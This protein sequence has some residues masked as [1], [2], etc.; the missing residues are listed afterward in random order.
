MTVTVITAAAAPAP[1]ATERP[2]VQLFPHQ[3]DAVQ[4]MQ[5]VEQRPRIVPEQPHGGI[6]AH[7]MGLG[8][9]ITMLSLVQAQGIG[10]T[11]V[12][13]PKSVLGQWREEA[14]R[15][16]DIP[17][18]SIVMYHGT[19]RQ[20]LMDASAPARRLILT[21]FDIVRLNGKQETDSE[22]ASNETQPSLLHQLHWDRVIL[23]EAHRICEQGSKTARAIRALKARNRWCVTG[24]PFKN[25]VT[26]LVALSKFLLVP[27]Y[28]N[29]TWWRCHSQNK[30]KLREW[31]NTF[32][33]MQDKS[34]LKLPCIDEVLLSTPRTTC[35][36]EFM[37]VIKEASILTPLSSV[38]TAQA[39]AAGTSLT[40][41][42]VTDMRA[43][44]FQDTAPQQEHEL[45]KIMRL[46][47]AANHP[48]MLSNSTAT[49][50]RLLSLDDDQEES[51]RSECSSCGNAVNPK[52]RRLDAAPGCTTK[53]SHVMCTTCASDMIA[54]MRCLAASLPVQRGSGKVFRHSGKTKALWDYLDV[55]LHRDESAKAVLFSQWT[56]CLDLL[57]LM[58]DVMGIK[59][60]RFDGRVN[61]IDERGDII[62][63]F[64][65]DPT[66]RVLLTSLGAG[67]EGLN[68]TFANHVILMEPYWNCAAEQQ[69]IDRLHRMGQS[70]VTNVLR[71]IAKDSIEDWV[72][73]IQVKKT[74]ELE[75]LLRGKDDPA[76]IAGMKPRPIFRCVD[77]INSTS[78]NSAGHVVFGAR[79]ATASA[80]SSISSLAQYL[81]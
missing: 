26:D 67:G 18:E 24:T 13:C 39:A 58:L 36:N 79:C 20:Q 62:A 28:C 56:T 27:P 34:V 80:M 45:L 25:G 8:K 47:Q 50:M 43:L 41:D 7:A 9:T 71:L 66:C 74:R 32:L 44:L 19:N 72:Q 38:P 75:R 17:S 51:D 22:Q 29:A 63:Q 65:E 77:A 76:G 42:E 37:Q 31:R 15:I 81:A 3:R 68:L 33:H 64:K 23:D 57:G 70:R 55:V 30:F 52:K 73:A 1:V 59:Y 40:L 78:N 61:S 14:H 46:R 48:L 54:C 69:A 4:W 11:I 6:L 53:C 2:N 21:T 16:L 49:M 35:E 60:A 5:Q 10:S 12:V